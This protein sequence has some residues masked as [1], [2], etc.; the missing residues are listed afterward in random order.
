M[1]KSLILTFALVAVIA[2]SSYA[3]GFH[4]GV[5]GGANIVKVDGQSFDQG[6]QVGYSLG[7]FAELNFTKKW[8]IQPE[9][10]WNQSKT[11]TANSFQ[12]IYEGVAGQDI[13][14]NYLSIPL[15]LTYRPVPIL[16]LQL[17]PQFGI[18]LNQNDNLFDNGRKAFKSGDFSMLGGAQLNLGGFRVGAR[19]FV[20]LN[21]IND[22]DNQ[23]K[24][25]N[26]GFQL[27]VGIRII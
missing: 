22:I 27:Y 4:L 3:Q 18:L 11:K 7:G 10:L 16:S 8:G 23:D 21:N 6:F 25:K 24:W 2:G 15:L 14:L 26:Q 20:G 12:Q 1:K 17:G 5:K 19:Y 13:T 9:V